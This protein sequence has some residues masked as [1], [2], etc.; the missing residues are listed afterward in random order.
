MNERRRRDFD[1]RHPV[2]TAVL[3]ALGAAFLYVTMT[4]GGA[5]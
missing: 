1:E 2:L 3:L 5:A 4:M